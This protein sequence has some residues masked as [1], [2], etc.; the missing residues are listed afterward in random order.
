MWRKSLEYYKEKG[1]K[2]GLLNLNENDF[3]Q[4][5]EPHRNDIILHNGKPST[6]EEVEKISLKDFHSAI[7]K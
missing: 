7:F 4:V 3:L 5:A 2:S 1:K 6:L